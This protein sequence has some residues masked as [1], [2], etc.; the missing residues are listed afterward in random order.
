[1]R[2]ERRPHDMKGVAIATVLGVEVSEHLETFRFSLV[3]APDRRQ[4]FQ[5]VDD[6]LSTN[7]PDRKGENDLPQ[8]PLGCSAPVVRCRCGAIARKRILVA[9][10]TFVQAAEQ[11]IDGRLEIGRHP[12]SLTSRAAL[13]KSRNSIDDRSASFIAI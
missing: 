8:P 11:D 7:A 5:V 3:A 12:N 4:R 1:M 10:E 6:V 2:K 9:A 13:L